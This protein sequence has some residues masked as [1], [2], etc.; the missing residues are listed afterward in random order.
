MASDTIQPTQTSNVENSTVAPLATLV[1]FASLPADTFAEGPPTGADISANGRTGPFA[2]PPVQGF[3]GVQ[4]APGGDGSNYWFLSDNGFGSKINSPDYLL[5]VYQVAPNWAGSEGGDGSVEIQ[6]FV[7]LS[8]P[9]DLIPFDIQ[10]EGTPERLLT[11]ADFDPESIVLDASGNLW[12]GEEFGPYLLQFDASGQLLQA[13]IATP[14]VNTL[15]TL[16]GQDPI[17]IGH[18]GASGERPEHTLA[19]YELAIEQGADFIEPDL[20]VTKDGVLI[21]RHENEISGTTDVADRPEF[22]DRQTTKIIDGAEFTGWFAEDFTLAELKTLRAKERIPDVRPGN[23]EFDGQFE[24]PTL[25]EV[26]NLVKQVEAETGRII[27]IYPETKHPTFLAKEGTFVDG[28]PINLD[29]SQILVDT[30][31]A[32][33][34][35]DP[36]RIFIQSFEVQNLIEIQARLDAEGL[37]D[38]PLVQLYGDTTAGADPNDSFSFPYD[39]RYNIAQGNDLA[40]IYGQDFLDTAENPLSANTLYADL[41]SP[42]MLQL[43]RNKYAEGVG[44][45]KNNILLREALDTPVDGNGDGVAEIS[46]Q[47]TG[48]ITSFIDDA[49][50]AGLQ[51]HPYTHRNEERFLTLNPDGTPQTPESE[52]AQLISIGADGFFTDFPATGDLV[53]DQVVADEVRSPDNP[54]V[55][56][57]EAVANLPRSRGFEGMAFSPDRAT[58]YPMLEG[59]VVG[60]PAGS[61]R[62]YEFDVASATYTGLAGLYQME[63]ASHAIGDFTPINVNEFV[64]IERDGNQ[65]EAAAF[66][67]IFKI[68]LADI[69]SRG[70]VAKEE[71]VDLLNIADPND[72]NGDG[73]TTFDFPFVTIEDLLVLDE[74]TLLVANDN[75]FPFS[76]GRGPDIDNN[77]I[78]QIELVKPLNLDSLLGVAGI[79][80]LSALFPSAADALT[81]VAS[82]G[83]GITIPSTA[84]I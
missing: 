79:E 17:V 48:E 15:I 40:A 51:V 21:A 71:V 42:E 19:A 23:T 46:T 80:R 34:F 56:A 74:D 45:W 28:T 6:G 82:A 35:T 32:E 4:F 60:D 54:A 20:V 76:I 66:K 9:S 77:E 2:G 31:I 16:N 24:V 67:K 41:D 30:L 55:L 36:S 69:D 38:I 33:G 5:R 78:I 63:S 29:T 52:L 84:L 39:I 65:G 43:L 8:D 12:I 72:L 14:N 49:H 11:G 58:L 26:I 7:Q 61:L 22:A 83:D 75:N 25:A 81:S 1:G 57:G 13:P 59:T 18:R 53:R 62:I 73:S 3:S 10:N 68:D 64:V 27:G 70:F 37:S 47:L 44:P 50:A